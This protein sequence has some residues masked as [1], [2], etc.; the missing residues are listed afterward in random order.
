MRLL[1]I[2]GRA[3]G[4]NKVTYLFSLFTSQAHTGWMIPTKIKG[5]NCKKWKHAMLL[6]LELQAWLLFWFNQSDITW[7]YS[8]VL[9]TV[10]ITGY[11]QCGTHT[12]TAPRKNSLNPRLLLDNWDVEVFYVRTTLRPISKPINRPTQFSC[13][14]LRNDQFELRKLLILLFG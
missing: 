3:V 7:K 12:W 2:F 13:W 8:P 1:Q 6:K 5:T 10:A 14:K 11:I 4:T 9:R